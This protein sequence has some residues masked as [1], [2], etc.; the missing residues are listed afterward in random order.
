MC[1]P[2]FRNTKRG[3][4]HFDDV[5]K[6]R[7]RRC[8]WTESEDYRDG[9]QAAGLREPSPMTMN[10]WPMGRYSRERAKP[11]TMT[12]DIQRDRHDFH[13]ERSDNWKE[14]VLGIFQ[15]A[16]IFPYCQLYTGNCCGTVQS[17]RRKGKAWNVSLRRLTRTVVPPYSAKLVRSDSGIWWS[18]LQ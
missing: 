7:S 8:L 2:Y 9:L 14:S 10:E 18:Q 13:T 16:L 15:L 17:C 11:R 1:Y 5:D 6:A 4:I 3:I 12:N